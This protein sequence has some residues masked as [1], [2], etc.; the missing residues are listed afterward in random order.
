MSSPIVRS[1]EIAAPAERV[2]PLLVE[3]ASLERWWP[4]VAELDARE[5]GRFR[6]RF[7]ESVVTGDVAVYEPP[8][9]LALTWVW[10]GRPSELETRIDLTITPL[11]GDRCR[12][13]VVHSGWERVPE[14][15]PAHDA[16][17]A[18]FLGSLAAL[19]E[20]RPFERTFKP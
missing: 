6:M 11:D 10:E 5:G 8:R 3:P 17:W 7:G 19:A 20:G 18:H 9:A 12:V 4:D 1:V 2:F 14:L 15:R 16:G 13:E